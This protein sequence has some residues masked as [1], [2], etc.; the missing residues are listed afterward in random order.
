MAKR[1]RLTPAQPGHFSARAPE[2]K[3]MPGPV[4]GPGFNA[5]PI[6]QVAGDTATHA[7]LDE[8]TGILQD[9]R[10]QGRLIEALPL[11]AINAHY[12]VR[13][14]LIQDDDEM[15]ALMASMR[16]RGQQT[17]I[18]VTVLSVSD[19]ASDHGPAYGLITG[20]R[21]LNALNRL[22][23]D[24]KDPRFSTVKAL[25][26][27]PAT[28]QDA[29][30][31]MVEENEIRVNLSLFERANIARRA[32]EEGIFPTSR[33]AVLGLFGTI[34]RSK[35]SKIHSFVALVEALDSVL[36]FPTA[37]P[38]KLGLALAKGLTADKQ[39]ARVIRDRLFLEAPQTPADELRIL[40]S[41]LMIKTSDKAVE[42]KSLK[43]KS[44]SVS[45][46]KTESD[47]APAPL[48]PGEVVPGLHLRMN[49]SADVPCIELTGVRADDALYHALRVWLADRYN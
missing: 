17:P 40:S 35:R 39:L 23:D 34:S 41:V 27:N 3:S 22:W 49:K 37:I 48:R 12:L 2:T 15:A 45:E 4:S 9:A 24:T 19:Q 32:A 38:E 11:A 28:A 26:V 46:A 42:N 18:E 33:H 36:R 30:V 7:A 8:V 16:A 43:R 6:A 20:W 31:S 10:A 13:D 21:R 1:K 47:I 14:R 5:P 44:E 29:Y 25:V